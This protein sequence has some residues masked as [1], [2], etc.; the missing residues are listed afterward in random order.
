[1]NAA[2]LRGDLPVVRLWKCRSAAVNTISLL[3]QIKMATLSVTNSE[4]VVASAME[5]NLI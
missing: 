4:L 5:T 2:Y 3:I 1:M